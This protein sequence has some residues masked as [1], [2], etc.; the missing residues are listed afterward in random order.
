VG[1]LVKAK[2]FD[3]LLEAVDG[4][5]LSLLIAGAGPEQQQL[6][7]QARQ[8]SPLTHCRFLGQRADIPSLMAS[9]DGV[10]ISSRREGFSYVFSEALLTGSRVLATDVPVANEV[11]PPEL[12]VDT[13]DP[14]ALRY[15]LKDMLE[16][17]GHWTSLMKTPWQF[18]S[19]RMTLDEMT[20]RTV[21]VYRQLIEQSS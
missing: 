19:Q 9:A 17:P 1:R 11:L 16:K 5:P 10:V 3:N 15:R 2:G 6:Q 13:E 12:I 8:L 14:Y 21:T 4:L 20:E 18:A 7:Q